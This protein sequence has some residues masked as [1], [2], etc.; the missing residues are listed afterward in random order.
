METVHEEVGIDGHTV[1]TDTISETGS[2]DSPGFPTQNKNETAT[3]S[4]RQRRRSSFFQRLRDKNAAVNGNTEDMQRVAAQYQSQD[5]SL[6]ELDTRVSRFRRQNFQLLFLLLLVIVG[7]SVTF[8]VASTSFASELRS[9]SDIEAL[10]QKAT[11]TYEGI[12]SLFVPLSGSFVVQR[13]NNTNEAQWGENVSDAVAWRDEYMRMLE[14]KTTSSMATDALA[15]QLSDQGDNGGLAHTWLDKVR[16]GFDM[17]MDDNLDVLKLAFMSNVSLR[18]AGVSKYYRANL[19]FGS[20][21]L[22]P[23]ERSYFDF[24]DSANARASKHGQRSHEQHRTLRV[25]NI[26]WIVIVVGAILVAWERRR[27]WL[28]LKHQLVC[29]LRRSKRGVERALQGGAFDLQIASATTDKE[30]EY[31]NEQNYTGDESAQAGSV[32]DSVPYAPSASS[33]TV[34]DA[35]TQMSASDS[36]SSGDTGSFSLFRS[37]ENQDLNSRIAKAKRRVRISSYF[38]SLLAIA[39]VALMIVNGTKTSNR[40]QNLVDR[41]TVVLENIHIFRSSV[42]RVL[43]VLLGL[44]TGLVL[45]PGMEFDTMSR[46]EAVKNRTEK[47]EVLLFNEVAVINDVRATLEPLVVG[48]ESFDEEDPYE[49][50]R[51]S[52][53]FDILYFILIDVVGLGLQG[54]I[55]AFDGIQSPEFMLAKNELEILFAQMTTAELKSIQQRTQDTENEVVAITTVLAITV[56]AI[57]ITAAMALRNS[58]KLVRLQKVASVEHV[59]TLDRVLRDDE[60]ANL[61]M[62]FAKEQYSHEN[63]EFLRQW[64]ALHVHILGLRYEQARTIYEQFIYPFAQMEVNISARLREDC[65]AAMTQFEASIGKAGPEKPVLMQRA[66][67]RIQGDD[68]AEMRVPESVIEQIRRVHDVVLRLVSTNLYGAFVV[69]P[70]F[71]KWCDARRRKFER[72]VELLQKHSALAHEHDQDS[73]SVE[74]QS[75]LPTASYP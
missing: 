31:D 58:R 23:A 24:L 57:G 49:W 47:L 72:E 55:T 68:V 66:P 39:A 67:D 74:M 15:Q 54:N 63:V 34:N 8:V 28:K 7:V 35:S 18:N 43:N 11:E 21:V 62:S 48:D 14:Y 50:Q 33:P 5:K 36:S 2:I 30:F 45:P 1:D 46:S 13:F 53:L 69:S 52:E 29:M 38:A 25:L 75:A 4:P 44:S 10:L 70:E 12:W 61:L 71:E 6:D 26:V 73:A 17:W 59:W 65:V 9:L 40:S 51:Q 3:T 16:P 20:D 56:F 60:A 19:E 32:V 41:D 42:A 27:R 22:L 37:K 64:N